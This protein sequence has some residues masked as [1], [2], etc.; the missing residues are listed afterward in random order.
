MLKGKHHRGGSTPL[1][2]ALAALALLPLL[3]FRIY[4]LLVKMLS[5]TR[6][7]GA[8]ARKANPSRGG[9]AKPK[10]LLELALGGGQATEQ[11]QRGH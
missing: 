2:T 5:C 10:D 11:Q 1:T 3:L 6:I 7:S 4:R 8:L 9:G